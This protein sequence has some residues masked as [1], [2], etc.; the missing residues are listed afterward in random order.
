[1]TPKQFA[2]WLQGFVELNDA[3]PTPE[4]WQAVRDHLA[5]VFE[6]VTP[7]SQRRDVLSTRL[8]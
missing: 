7:P 2:Y 4:Q 3:P 6:K 5:L 1:M 8:C